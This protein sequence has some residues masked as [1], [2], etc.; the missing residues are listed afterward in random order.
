MTGL[1]R[2]ESPVANRACILDVHWGAAKLLVFFQPAL[3]VTPGL[4]DGML[5]LIDEFE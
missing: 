2:A 3:A 5:I 1:V 4:L